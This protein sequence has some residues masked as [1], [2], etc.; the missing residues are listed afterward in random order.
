[1]FEFSPWSREFKQINR[2]QIIQRYRNNQITN[3]AD[4]LILANALLRFA[5]VIKIYI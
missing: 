5:E 2:S 3:V 1:M 4:S